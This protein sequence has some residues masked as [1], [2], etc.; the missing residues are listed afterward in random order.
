MATNRHD[1][2]VQALTLEGATRLGAHWTQR[3]LD[4]LAQGRAAS[5]TAR[6]LATDL[7]R[8]LYG[9]RNALRVPPQERREKALA[10]RRTVLPYDRGFTTLEEMGF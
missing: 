2:L 1:Q 5:R 3:E 8:S 6:E 4:R 10:A 9:V 7:N